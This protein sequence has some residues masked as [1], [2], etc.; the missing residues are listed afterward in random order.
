[1]LEV[2]VADLMQELLQVLVELEVVVQVPNVEM[3][4]QQE[5]PI[6]EAEVAALVIQELMVEQAAQV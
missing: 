4:E 3:L 2:V 5:Q 6:L 1:L